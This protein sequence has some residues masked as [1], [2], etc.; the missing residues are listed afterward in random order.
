MNLPLK[1][2]LTIWYVTLFALIVGV[3]SV[4]VVVL[5]RVELRSATDRTLA[6]S[7][8]Q[9][10]DGYDNTHADDF[11]ELSDSAVSGIAKTE[12]AAQLLAR[13]GTVLQHVGDAFATGPIATSALLSKA[14]RTGSTQFATITSAGERFRIL[15]VRVPKQSRLILVGVATEASEGAVDRLILVMLLTGPLVLIAAGVGGWLLSQ[16]AL[17]PIAQMNSTA[18]SIGIDRLDERVPV[19]SAHDELR[20]LA[21]TLN[22][23]L[24]RLEEGV[25]DKR[26]LIANASHE[27]QTPLAVMRTE[28]D[29]SLASSDLTPSAIDVLESAREEIDRMTRIV[30]NLLTLARFDEGTLRLLRSRVDLHVLAEGAAESLVSLA[31]ERSITLIVGAGPAP[32]YADAEYLRMVVG[33]LL[34]NAIKYSAAGATVTLT[35]YIEGSEVVLQVADTGPG[36][37]AEAVP[38]IFDRFFRVDP[39]RTKSSGGSGLGLAICRDIVDAHGGAITVH[40][41]L[42]SGSA[43]TVRLLRFRDQEASGI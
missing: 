28:L 24:S 17:R 29:V 42:G 10:A 25:K 19:P 38:H 27:L 31:R 36:I 7:A 8:S 2:R 23:M 34:E 35:S 26:R 12:A 33:N 30:R 3:W 11:Q 18:A 20:A 5:V 16:R 22:K 15:V 32:A 43:F 13:D 39:S 40:S 9:I 41:E 37:P 4:F 14:F 6:S 1:A 21:D